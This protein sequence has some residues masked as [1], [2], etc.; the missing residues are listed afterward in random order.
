M[1][2]SVYTA[3]WRAGGSIVDVEDHRLDIGRFQNWALGNLVWN[4]NRG[5]YAE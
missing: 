1:S 5:V 4:T 2:R 3:G